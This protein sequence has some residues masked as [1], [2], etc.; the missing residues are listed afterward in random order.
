MKSRVKTRQAG[1]TGLD[2][3]S[4]SKSQKERNQVSGRISVPCWHATLVA[5]TPKKYG[6]FIFFTFDKPLSW[7][8]LVIACD[9]ELKDVVIRLG[10]F[11]AEM[12]F[13]EASG[14]LWEAL[15]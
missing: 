12:S 8:A 15:D 1:E 6:K 7:K 14:E 5:N 10:T 13:S 11:H 3:R 2:N 4:I 9:T